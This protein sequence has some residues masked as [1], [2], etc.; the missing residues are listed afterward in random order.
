MPQSD[1][2]PRLALAACLALL[3][4]LKAQTEA[5]RTFEGH[6]GPVMDVAISEDGATLLTASFDYA[7]GLWPVGDDAAPV[8]LDGH[9]AAVNDVVFLADDRAASGGDDFAVIL[10]NLADGTAERQFNGH[11]GKVTAVA[12]HPGGQT[13]ASASWDGTIRLWDLTSGDNTVLSGHDSGVNDIIWTADGYL[14]SAGA[15][16]AVYL[17]DTASDAPTRTLAEH[18]FGVNRLT[19]GP[20]WLAYGA[21][22]G[23]TRILDLATGEELAD[24]TLERRPILS[25]ALSRDGQ[26]LA[27]GDGEGYIMVVDTADWTITRDFRAAVNGPIWALAF[28]AEGGLIAGGIADEAY[29]WPLD[30]EETLP[31]MAEA[32]RA[33][34]TDPNEVSNG[35]RQFLRKC[36]ICHTLGPDGE[37]RAGPTLYGVF[38]RRAGEL[39]GYAYSD[40]LTGSDLVWGE[41]TIDQ[42]FD[43]GPDVLT[44]GS[45]MPMQQI[46]SPQDRADLV[47][48]LKERTAPADAK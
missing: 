43:V 33:F 4:P 3:L 11:Q 8:W 14:I 13:L 37:R 10:W 34:H 21:V 45:K 41:D 31:A 20:G 28:T 44:P 47:A 39:D 19:L 30:G 42:L 25:M 6:G 29:L 26:H 32:P 9:R 40:A 23:G 1:P 35:E 12:P 48:F 38:G 22:D 16:G 7:V 2:K 15:D 17:W 46:A 18:G 24:L 5:F 27:V 36:S